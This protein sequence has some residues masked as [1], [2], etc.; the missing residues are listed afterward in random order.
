MCY[1]AN[2]GDSRGVIS[3]YGGQDIQALTTD[4]KPSDE[5]EEKRIISAGGKVYQYIIKIIIIF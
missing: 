4:H 2:V 3:K 1:I 5:N